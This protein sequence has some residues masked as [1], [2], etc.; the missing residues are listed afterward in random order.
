VAA[1]VIGFMAGYLR[2]VGGDSSYTTM[3][4]R[5][6]TRV[7][8]DTGIQWGFSFL[9]LLGWVA[10]WNWGRGHPHAHGLLVLVA[11]TNLLYHFPPLMILQRMLADRPELISEP[12]VTRELALDLIL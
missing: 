10:S 8:L 2:Y 3:L 6:P 11:A 7:Y 1:G 9:C 5:F 12:I 4:A